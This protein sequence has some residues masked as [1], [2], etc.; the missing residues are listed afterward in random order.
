MTIQ[1]SFI[2]LHVL[3]NP[4]A[5]VVLVGREIRNFEKYPGYSLKPF[6]TYDVKLQN[7]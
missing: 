2:H 3:P 7:D 1:P 6:G 5:V 4:N